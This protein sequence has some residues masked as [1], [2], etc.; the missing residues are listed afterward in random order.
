MLEETRIYLIR[1]G[2]TEWSLS[3]Q[4]SGR[5]DLPLTAHGEEEALATA[6]LLN[7]RQFDRV[8][9]STLQRARRTC[10]LAG[11]A[12]H[13]VFDP[14]LQEWDYGDCTGYT[15]EQIREWM[16][17]WT[18]WDGPVPNGESIQEIASRARRVGERIRQNP[19]STALFAHGH[20]LRILATQWLELPP[21]NGSRLAL[22]T[23]SVSILG[24]DTGYPA[25]LSWN[26]RK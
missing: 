26:E 6:R 17:G 15:Q 19:G 25:I 10:E 24:Y 9:C 4:H 22:E 16:P 3:G 14:E 13:A 8:W 2:E 5:K 20:F 18:I 23:A 11:Y 1:H 7:G 21:E 12:V